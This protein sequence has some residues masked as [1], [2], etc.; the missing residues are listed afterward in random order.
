MFDFG[1]QIGLD[2]RNRSPLM[3]KGY[4]FVGVDFASSGS[5]AWVNHGTAIWYNF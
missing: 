1:L 4:Q 5:I 3:P 2:S